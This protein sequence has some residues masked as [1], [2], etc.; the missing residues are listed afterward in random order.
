MAN[1]KKNS[2][3]MSDRALEMIMRDVLNSMEECL[4]ETAYDGSNAGFEIIDIH[5]PHKEQ[6]VHTGYEISRDTTTSAEVVHFPAKRRA[7][8]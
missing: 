3:N 1:T 2:V 4:L 7:C 5:P 8:S 6:P